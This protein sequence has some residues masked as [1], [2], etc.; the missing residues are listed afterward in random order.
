MELS[1]TG[2]TLTVDVFLTAAQLRGA[3]EDDV[4]HGLTA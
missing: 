1:M 4:L 2:S 3:L